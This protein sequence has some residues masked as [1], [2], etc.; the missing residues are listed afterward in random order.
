MKINKRNLEALIR[1]L[2]LRESYG[3]K[4]FLGQS[5]R[6]SPKV[7]NTRNELLLRVENFENWLKNNS[8]LSLDGLMASLGEKSQR[9]QINEL[10]QS[11]GYEGLFYDDADLFSLKNY[12]NGSD[13]DDLTFSVSFFRSGVASYRLGPLY[14]SKKRFLKDESD[15]ISDIVGSPGAGRFVY[16]DIAELLGASYV[17]DGDIGPYTIE[18]YKKRKM[19]S[20]ADDNDDVLYSF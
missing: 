18:K 3:G 13:R 11:L 1:N 5:D 14:L 6:L 12:Y 16:A 7:T 15:I 20:I 2:L 4:S 9:D 8:N 10:V 17:D 19:K